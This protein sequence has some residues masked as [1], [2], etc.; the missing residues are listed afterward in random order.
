MTSRED[1]GED[2]SDEW[3]R[4]SKPVGER[5]SR[6][7]RGEGN[8]RRDG[9]HNSNLNSGILATEYKCL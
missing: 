2:K 8:E 5:S 3:K 6:P 7:L 9:E 4:N 1:E